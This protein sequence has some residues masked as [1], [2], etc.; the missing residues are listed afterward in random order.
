MPHYQHLEKY[1]E[2]YVVALIF[3]VSYSN[4][5]QPFFKSTTIFSVQTF[6]FFHIMKTETRLDPKIS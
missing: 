4:P 1:T 2:K 3:H 6:H 5:F